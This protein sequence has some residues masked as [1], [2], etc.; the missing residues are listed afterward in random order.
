MANN[1][2]TDP[3]AIDEHLAFVGGRR[4]LDL[5]ATLRKRFEGGV[6]TLSDCSSL[7]AWLRRADLLTGECPCSKEDLHGARA[8]REAVYSA[9]TA[10]IHGEPVNMADIEFINQFAAH[11]DLAP[12]LT[13]GSNPSHMQSGWLGVPS[14]S[15]ALATIARDAVILLSSGALGRVKECGN[16]KCSLLFQDDSQGRRR[17]WCSME[18]CGN[19]VKIAGYR[20]RRKETQ[21]EG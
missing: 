8:L 9:V 16:P 4:C 17:T 14:V 20:N 15:S 12:Q 3:L 11:Q 7:V 13:L 10:L 1:S 18:R 21:A 2:L 19:R 6:E 5:T